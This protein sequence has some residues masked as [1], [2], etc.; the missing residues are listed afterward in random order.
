MCFK[1]QYVHVEYCALVE[2][3]NGVHTNCVIDMCV[4]AQELIVFI[5]IINK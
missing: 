2:I 1:C 4:G 5:L 3:T